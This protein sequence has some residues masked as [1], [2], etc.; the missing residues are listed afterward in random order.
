MLLSLITFRIKVSHQALEHSSSSS[1]LSRGYNV[2]HRVAEVDRNA[3]GDR[4]VS[5]PV[6]IAAQPAA[7]RDDPDA[8]H[9]HTQD[10]QRCYWM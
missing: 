8:Q 5:A 3:G 7:N 1:R 4:G 9:T 6:P 2:A 10:S